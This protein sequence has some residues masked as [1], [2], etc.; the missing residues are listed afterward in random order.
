MYTFKHSA[1]QMKYNN[2]KSQY[3]L[4]HLTLYTVAR[5]VSLI[6]AQLILSLTVSYCSQENVRDCGGNPNTSSH[7]WWNICGLIQHI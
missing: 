5:A 3:N 6:C 7:V 2:F 1:R 4:F